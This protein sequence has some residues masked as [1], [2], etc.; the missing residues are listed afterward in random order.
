MNT[1]STKFVLAMT[2]VA[3]FVSGCETLDPYTREGK[4]S[5]A[6]KGALIGAAAGAV[7]VRRRREWHEVS[8]DELRAHLH[9][10][11]DKAR[12]EGRVE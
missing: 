6:T 2:L 11:L 1:R 5:K 12:A 9:A 7:V 8:Q 4:T 10:R 3:V